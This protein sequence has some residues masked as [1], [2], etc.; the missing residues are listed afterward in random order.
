MVGSKRVC[1]LYLAVACLFSFCGREDPLNSNQKKEW[2]YYLDKERIPANGKKLSL[3]NSYPR[4]EAGPN[5]MTA[6]AFMIPGIENTL[7]VTD[8]HNHEVLKIDSGGQLQLRIGRYGQGPNEFIQ[9]LFIGSDGQNQIYVFDGAN[10]RTQIFDADGRYLRSFKTFRPCYSMNV[11]ERGNI[12]FAFYDDDLESGLITEF[13]SGGVELRQFGSRLNGGSPGS[14][15]DVDSCAFKDELYVAWRTYPLIRKYAH[16]GSIVFEKCLDYGLM[17]EFGNANKA[18]HRKDGRI[19]YRGVISK[20]RVTA[21][22]CF[23]L[24]TYPRLEVLR[25]DSHGELCAIYWC[26]TPYEFLAQDFSISMAGSGIR[27]RVLEAAPD[28]RIRVYAEENGI[29]K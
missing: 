12:Y 20:I 10:Q 5:F 2:N 26:D 21:E 13:D 23:L 9:P 18:A 3:I 8:T 1:I 27:I 29:S 6:P 25:L 14:F 17:R 11:S 22:G 7:F 19:S 15:N 24:R 4:P 28:S 16:D